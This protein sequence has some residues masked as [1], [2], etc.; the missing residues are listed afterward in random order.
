MISFLFSGVVINIL[1]LEVNECF[2][3]QQQATPAEQQAEQRQRDQPGS[4]VP[5][6]CPAGAPI[7]DLALFPF[8]T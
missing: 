3:T 2:D 1:L 8:D 4:P 7:S 5:E 6:L